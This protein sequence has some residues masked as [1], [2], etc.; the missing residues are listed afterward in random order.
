[1]NIALIGDAILVILNSWKS[2]EPLLTNVANVI[3]A[4]AS[5]TG[6]TGSP[7]L[8]A[9]LRVATEAE[10]GA[11]NLANGQAAVVASDTVDGI[12][13]SAVIV[14]NNSAAGA[15][16]GLGTD[17]NAAADAAPAPE[18]PPAAT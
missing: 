6:I 14:K 1:M 17:P 5:V 13:Y 3:V 9:V 11:A 16:L 12:A 7:L 4:F 18:T 8:Q 2:G 15:T 10:A